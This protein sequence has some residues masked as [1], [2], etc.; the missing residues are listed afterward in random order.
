MLA[1]VSQWVRQI[2]MV[3]MFAAFVD[4]FI[5]EKS[6]SRY[7]KVFL[8]LLVM[9][10]IMSPVMSLF[11]R[12]FSIDEIA[13]VYDDPIDYRSINSKSHILS[14]NNDKIKIAEYK[15]N[16]EKYIFQRIAEITSHD[17]RDV[18]VKLVEDFSSHDFGQISEIVITLNKNPP[19]QLADGNVK[20]EKISIEKVKIDN[21]PLGSNVLS[22]MTKEEFKEIVNYLAASFNIPEEKI[23]ISLED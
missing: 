22:E 19:G 21:K 14:E 2:V 1:A 23:Y 6:F 12:D 18:S 9:I 11:H 5:P 20:Q 15:A 13:F 10:V 4:F 17:L 8:G 7:V 3:V 16:I